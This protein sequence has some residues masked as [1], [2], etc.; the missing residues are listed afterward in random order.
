MAKRSTASDATISA[1]GVSRR[2]LIQ[3]TAAGAALAAMPAAG[4]LAQTPEP[5]PAENQVLQLGGESESPGIWF[6]TRTSGGVETQVFDLIFSRL[7][8]FDDGYNLI[9]DLAESYE[10]SDDATVF[11]FHLRQNVQWSDG[12]PFTSK[13]VMFT[14]TLALRP[15]VG[16]AQYN[17]LRQ[18]KGAEAFGNGETDTVEGLEAPDDFTFKITLASP[19]V[20]FLI[21]NA[22]GNSLIWI[23]PEH[24]VGDIDPAAIDQHPF[25]HNPNVGT[26]PFIYQE[27]ASDQYVL[28]N[29]N[30]T[31]FLGAPKL[32]QVYV[33]LG[34]QA[35]QLAQLES[36]ELHVMQAI[37]AREA[38][39]LSSSEVVNIVPTQGV[40]M[41]QTAIFMERFPDKRVRQAFM[42]GTDRQAIMDVVLQGQGTL[43][44]SS[45][46]GPEWAQFDDLNTYAFDPE[47]AKALLAEAGW[48]SAR[49]VQVIW[50]SGYQAIETAAPVFQQQMA[51]IGVKVELMPMEEEAFEAKV[52]EE[53]DFDL[54][55]FGGGAYYLDP[56]VSSTY[57]DSA[58]WTP[59]GGNATHFKS[60]ELDQLF[61]DGRSTP[62]IAQRT[63]IYHRAAQILN[64]EVPTI[65]WWS[66]NMIWGLNKKL[67]GVIPGP[68]TDIHWNIQEWWLSE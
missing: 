58:N 6:P 62:D 45:I 28:V 10:V 35:T 33:R 12:T 60:E 30:P 63:E 52:L 32:S 8:R 26:G 19:N 29:A 40:G 14:Y 68:N 44:N 48:D 5:H 42:Y 15:E 7:I 4:A 22:S 31:Y 11:T 36:G 54:S 39:R 21:G 24:V 2:A 55:W 66:E 13:D 27:Y 34:T 57:Y 67:Q 64:E 51:E 9:P 53:L 50:E 3:G 47:K 37:D 20:A 1:S 65:F 46:F 41:F 61:I 56:D 17:K 59:N 23:V 18:I 49:T 38:E 43:V 25:V 16:A